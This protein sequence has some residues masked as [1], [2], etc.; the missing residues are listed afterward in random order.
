[1]TRGWSDRFFG[2]T[3]AATV[4]RSPHILEGYDRQYGSSSSVASNFP[5]R[6]DGVFVQNTVQLYEIARCPCHRMAGLGSTMGLERL[7]IEQNVKHKTPKNLRQ[8]I[9]AFQQLPLDTVVL[10]EDNL[11]IV[12]CIHTF[13]DMLV[14]RLTTY[15][16]LQD[17][18]QT[19]SAEAS[20]GTFS[21]G[22]S[23]R[24]DAT[25]ADW[26]PASEIVCVD[27]RHISEYASKYLF[28]HLHTRLFPQEPTNS[29]L[30]TARNISILAWLK[31]S[32]LDVPPGLMSL[33]QVQQAMV[34]LRR[35]CRLRS[36]G[37]MLAALAEAF[38]KVTEAAGLTAQLQAA[39]AAKDQEAF[40]ADDLVPLFI[41]VVLRANPPMFSSVL[42]YTEA[43]TTRTQ[44]FTAQGYAFTQFQGAEAF[45]RSVGP[46]SLAGLA[47][48]EWERH[49]PQLAQK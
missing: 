41:M 9:L 35:L 3:E 39:T 20:T 31:P 25:T 10:T 47:P 45:T 21:V 29:D 5:D 11:S 4:P 15:C 27:E 33:T 23:S 2:N 1:M 46:E 14:A 28:G 16:R 40:G 36:P 17:P 22:Q 26:E 19:P 34:I 38:R 37:E 32:H 12:P 49:M 42:A 6:R 13:L 30:R 7:D 8:A 18:L 43:L 48:G 44:M 24:M